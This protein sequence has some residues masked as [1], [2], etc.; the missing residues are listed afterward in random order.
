MVRKIKKKTRRPAAPP[1]GRRASQAAQPSSWLVP[2]DDE[3]HAAVYIHKHGDTDDHSAC[4]PVV[5]C[6]D[7]A[8]APYRALAPDLHGRVAEMKPQWGDHLTSWLDAGVQAMYFV[9]C[10]PQ[11]PRAIYQFGLPAEHA[12]PLLLGKVPHSAFRIPERRFVA[13]A[14]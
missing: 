3:G 8:A 13:P 2:F 4:G 7:R 1:P 11:D 10:D 9:L 5:M 14:D 6:C 12:R